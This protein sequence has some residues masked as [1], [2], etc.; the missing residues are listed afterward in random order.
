MATNGGFTREHL[1]VRDRGVSVLILVG[2]RTGAGGSRAG[3]G[4]RDLVRPAMI[5]NERA[6]PDGW[7]PELLAA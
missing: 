4:I 5:D 1:R 7:V 2:H 6:I 3:R